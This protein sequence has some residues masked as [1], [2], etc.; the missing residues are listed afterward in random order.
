MLL[1]VSMVS[2]VLGKLAAA[3]MSGKNGRDMRYVMVNQ[4]VTM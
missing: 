1:D 4:S 2:W 3:M